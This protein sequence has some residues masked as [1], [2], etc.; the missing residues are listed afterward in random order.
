M[1]QLAAPARARWP[2]SENA[3]NQ[4]EHFPQKSTDGGGSI[5]A[6][7]ARRV[8]GRCEGGDAPK[9]SLLSSNVLGGAR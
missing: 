3:F 7:L 4:L 2:L 5:G 8:A 6:N 9:F 1:Q